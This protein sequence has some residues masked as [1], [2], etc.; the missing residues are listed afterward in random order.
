[1]L[2]G[3]KGSR[4]SWGEFSEAWYL[5]CEREGESL[6]CWS[7]TEFLRGGEAFGCRGAEDM[8]LEL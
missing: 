4:E 5:F 1:M 6:G 7:E 3:E 8:F 2:L